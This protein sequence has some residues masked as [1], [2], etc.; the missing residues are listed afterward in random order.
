MTESKP[1][2]SPRFEDVRRPRHV[3]HDDDRHV[4]ADGGRRPPGLQ[5]HCCLAHSTGMLGS[6]CR[7]RYPSPPSG[8][9][10]TT[11]HTSP[12]CRCGSRLSCYRAVFAPRAALMIGLCVLFGALTQMVFQGTPTR[13]GESRPD[14]YLEDVGQFDDLAGA[15][16]AKPACHHVFSSV[17]ALNLAATPGVPDRWYLA[18]YAV[19]LVAAVIVR[20]TSPRTYVPPARRPQ[21]MQEICRR[22]IHLNIDGLSWYWFRRSHMPFLHEMMV[23][24]ASCPGRRHYGLSGVD[25]PGVCVDPNGH[26][27]ACARHPQQQSRPIADHR[28]ATRSRADKALR[29]RTHEALFQAKLGSAMVQPRR[30]RRREDR[31]LAVRAA[32]E[33]VANRPELR[34]FIVDISEMDFTGHSYG[35]YS[36]QYREAASRADANIRDFYTWLEENGHLEDTTIIISSDHGLWINDHSYMISEQEKFTPLIFL[37][38]QVTRC[39]FDGQPSIMDINANISYLWVSDTINIAP[40]SLS[41]GVCA[42]KRGDGQGESRAPSTRRTFGTQLMLLV[43]GACGFLGRCVVQMALDQNRKVR[44]LVRHFDRCPDLPRDILVKDDIA[45]PATLESAV[46]GVDAVIHCA[47][48]TSE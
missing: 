4:C 10:I 48:T 28:C 19:L 44:G 6:S 43:T 14:G 42:G 7:S 23:R 2:I 8:S 39:R 9:P 47:A 25:Q 16:H 35:S 21:P 31:T 40:G 3:L 33:D 30:T 24:H 38:P 37:G 11:R 27:A 17:L 12:S 15:D 13:C 34:L 22:V 29:Q 26:T 5:S 32:R 45:D 1:R 18:H 46:A 41:S 36:K 20:L